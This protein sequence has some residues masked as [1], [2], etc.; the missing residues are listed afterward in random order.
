MLTR[1]LAAAL[2]PGK[3]V[4]PLAR[5]VMSTSFSVL[6]TVDAVRAVVNDDDFVPPA[7]ARVKSVTR[8]CIVSITGAEAVAQG[9]LVNV[10]SS[11]PGVGC[12]AAQVI[13]VHDNE[14]IAALFAQGHEVV[15]GDTVSVP[16][17][18]EERVASFPCGSA[19]LGRV[20]S[21]RG[22]PLDGEPAPAPSSL[23]LVPL[24]TGPGAAAT[25][26]IAARA[27]DGAFFFTGLKQ[28]DL[29][30]PLRRGIR[31]AFVGERSVDLPQVAIDV[32]AALAAQNGPPA[33]GG[34]AGT[35][36]VVVYACVGQ[37]QKHLDSVRAQLAEAGVAALTA[38]VFAEHAAPPL[39][40]HAA[41]LAAVA[42]AAHLRALGL[43]VVV[44]VDDIAAHGRA[45]SHLFEGFNL[46]LTFA[47]G[48]EQARVLEAF[49]PLQQ[50]H[51][52]G[53]ATALC[54]A[55]TQPALT[56]V[57]RVR[58]DA[59]LASLRGA[60]DHTVDLNAHLAGAGLWPP[61]E[62]AP[63]VSTL[64]FAF[65][66]F[67]ALVQRLNAML[68]RS[69]EAYE[70]TAVGQDLGIE[71]DGD[72]VEVIEWRPKL[73]LLLSQPRGTFAPP[74]TQYLLAFA[75]L[76][77]RLLAGIPVPAVRG[78]ERF[79]CERAAT[80]QPELMSR[81]SAHILASAAGPALGKLG[82]GGLPAD[83]HDALAAFCD[84]AVSDYAA[85]VPLSMH[86]DAA[87]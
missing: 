17:A 64:R 48:A 15:A 82:A 3:T 25:P 45:L 28:M 7:G 46:P 68:V 38:V 31:A 36:T 53:S 58:A 54:L 42:Q 19:W 4:F 32:V 41:V 33:L 23:T 87:P 85:T 52:G 69:K 40:Q 10:H 59:V 8:G 29:L 47:V 16:A 79:L 2:A 12:V 5:R 66:A 65:P 37:S 11:V 14:A 72:V 75:A 49:A 20:V 35:P 43:D 62:A 70:S 63:T 27:A 86:S 26:S 30:H 67:R 84:A 34:G 74:H 39:E 56:G 78:F 24:T 13:R 73:Q 21:S 60:V 6:P 55:P 44:V 1:R 50:S 57:D 9:S 51:G 18:P 77:P 81:L 71:P 22:V 76:R 83:L 80:Q 61:V